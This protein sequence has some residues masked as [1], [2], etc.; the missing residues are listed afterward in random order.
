MA[1]L[2]TYSSCC[3]AGEIFYINQTD[4]GTVR[5]FTGVCP[6]IVSLIFFWLLLF[7]T[8]SLRMRFPATRSYRSWIPKFSLFLADPRGC[9]R[10]AAEFHGIRQYIYV[11]YVA[12]K[13]CSR[14]I[15]VKCFRLYSLPWRK[16]KE[17]IRTVHPLG[18]TTHAFSIYRSPIAQLSRRLSTYWRVNRAHAEWSTCRLLS[19]SVYIAA[20]AQCSP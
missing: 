5:R 8:F 12:T 18:C 9:A 2:N 1:H 3:Y 6:S 20:V 10:C 4:D 15:F 19:T 13:V 11:L 14:Y 7:Y 16:E 17:T